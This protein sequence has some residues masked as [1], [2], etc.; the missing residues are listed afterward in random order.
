MGKSHV[1]GLMAVMLFAMLGVGFA[2]SDTTSN[3]DQK[4]QD[5]VKNLYCMVKNLLPVVAL[6]MVFAAAVIYALGQML[7]AEIRARANVWAHAMFIGAIIG[8]LL[9]LVVPW[10]L[11]TI[12][13][14]TWT[15][16]TCS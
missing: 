2:G 1:I 3:P 6:L 15:S 4:I 9:S 16:V 5:A 12:Y 8:I 11:K 7:G 10:I 14:D 13:A